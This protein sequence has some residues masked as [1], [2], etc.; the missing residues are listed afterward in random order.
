MHIRFTATYLGKEYPVEVDFSRRRSIG[1]RLDEKSESLSVKA[2][3]LT[4]ERTLREGVERFLPRLVKRIAYERPC[5]DGIL[6]ILG[7][8]IVA[9]EFAADEDALR[10]Y[11]KAEALPLFGERVIYY[12]NL[13]GVS[14]LYKVRARDMKSR[15]GVN[16][17]RTHAITLATSLVHYSLPIIDSVV[18]HELAHHFYFD[19]SEA[20][21][22]VVY[23]YCPDYKAL[24]AKLRKHIYS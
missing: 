4:S 7:K 18:V 16:S 10:K 17:K 1:F 8:P 5:H 13:M 12:E 24:H 6:Y 2:P 9:P 11:L 19:H 3:Y 14:P 23:R 21:Y 20:F 15:Y 22:A